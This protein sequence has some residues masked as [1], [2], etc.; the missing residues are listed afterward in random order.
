MEL[1]SIYACTCAHTLT[2]HFSQ[3]IEPGADEK[4]NSS[5][6]AEEDETNSEKPISPHLGQYQQCTH[7]R[8]IPKVTNCTPHE[9]LYSTVLN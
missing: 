7:A 5:D 4:E 2:P 1:T 3:V 9:V 8:I 6:S